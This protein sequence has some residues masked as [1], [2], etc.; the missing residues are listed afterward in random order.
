MW[1]FSKYGYFSIVKKKYGDQVKDYQVRARS[2]TDLEQLLQHTPI[3]ERIIHTPNADYHYRITVDADELNDILSTLSH[4]IEYDNFKGEIGTTKEQKDK[5][6]SYHQIWEVM[7]RYQ[8]NNKFYDLA[9]GENYC[10]EVENAI[11]PEP[12]NRSLR[13]IFDVYA[14][15]WEDN[16]YDEKLEM[17]NKLIKHRPLLYW[18]NSYVYYYSKEINK[19]YVVGE[20]PGVLKGYYENGNDE[21]KKEIEPLLGIKSFKL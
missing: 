4:S 6:P 18:I 7:H 3:L 21:L 13:C 1:I 2:Y 9:F 19:G 20:I 14:S 17:L 11:G 10:D 15:E 8:A 5:L 16:S 12:S